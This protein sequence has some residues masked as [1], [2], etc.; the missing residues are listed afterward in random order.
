M[1]LTFSASR[2]KR[3][4]RSVGCSGPETYWDLAS[5]LPPP[6]AQ[7]PGFRY[8]AGG[9]AGEHDPEHL[10]GGEPRGG[11]AHLA[12]THYRPAAVQRS[13]VGA[14]GPAAAGGREG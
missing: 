10:G 12:T 6:A 8:P 4:G 11:G 7:A 5:R 13:Q 1:D 14:P 9:A 2:F 3:R